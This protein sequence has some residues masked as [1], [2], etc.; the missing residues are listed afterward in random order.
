MA[1]GRVR[2]QGI[3]FAPGSEGRHRRPGE[4]AWS[5][6]ALEPSSDERL[7]RFLGWFSIGLGLA[8]VVAPRAVAR[9]I[10]VRE[11]RLLLRALGL[12]ELAS[13]A[14][15]LLQ[16]RP[17]GWLWGRVAGDVM[18]LS[19]L[20]AAS[21]SDH[22]GRGRV[23]AATAAVTAVTA[24]DVLGAR[25]LSRSDA[26]TSGTLTRDGAI[27]VNKSVVVER[28]PEEIYRFWRD[29]RNLTR[30]MRH[31][32]SV[33]VTSE[34]RSHWV[35]RAPA[36]MTVE[37]D[38]EIVDEAPNR[39]IAWR[40]LPGAHIPHAGSVRF[41]PAPGGRGTV[42][43]VEMEYRPPGGTMAS[44]IARLFGEEPGQQVREDLRRLKQVLE[45]GEVP[46]TTGQPSG[47]VGPASSVPRTGA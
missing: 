2:R 39:R 40:S 4:D 15:I 8:Q 12:R 22:T 24:L 47:P 27:R 19:L 20:A 35:A 25:R 28:P 33:E 21:A 45:A 17:A 41:E 26:G 1:V 31:L 10:G 3:G 29:F 11:H 30:F 16:R 9:A 5:R 42:V 43:R 37:W 32:E 7:A 36:G 14:G 6:R 13:G 38:A 34:T 46:T 44:L 18:D 23:A